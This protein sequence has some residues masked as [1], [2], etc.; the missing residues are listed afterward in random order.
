MNKLQLKLIINQ[1]RKEI[2][3]I[4]ELIN[5]IAVITGN[6][7]PLR[8]EIEF[9]NSK[10]YKLLF[11]IKENLGQKDFGAIYDNTVSMIELKNHDV[12]FSTDIS[13]IY[14]FK[15]FE[16]SYS[17]ISHFSQNSHFPSSPR[18]L[19]LIDGTLIS[20]TYY[21]QSYYKP[22]E[23]NIFLKFIN[24][25]FKKEPNNIFK[26]S[27][28]INIKTDNFDYSILNSIEIKPYLLVFYAYSYNGSDLIVYSLK[29]KKIM[30]KLISCKSFDENYYFLSKYKDKYFITRYN[31]GYRKEYSKLYF[32]FFDINNYKII[33]KIKFCEEVLYSKKFNDIFTSFQFWKFY[34]WKINNFN[35]EKITE[36]EF[37]EKFEPGSKC[38]KSKKGNI[39][40]YSRDCFSKIFIYE[41]VKNKNI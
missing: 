37:Q 26:N 21:I 38:F 28:K 11:I 34:E 36:H 16:K 6:Y 22:K 27:Y 29:N 19:N 25:I 33:H 39:I 10:T 31:E 13:E 3:L 35:I 41:I 32:L 12:A 2:L 20:Y 5:K 17:L 15:I 40:I 9:Y 8:Q 14:I 4:Y 7:A 30:K 23:N 18:F 24:N 1:S